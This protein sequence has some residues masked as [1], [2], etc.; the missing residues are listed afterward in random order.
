MA[1]TTCIPLTVFQKTY[2]EFELEDKLLLQAS[3]NVVDA[4]I[5]KLYSRKQRQIRVFNS[6]FLF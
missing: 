2:P 1:E 5:G 4:F 6:V 3:S